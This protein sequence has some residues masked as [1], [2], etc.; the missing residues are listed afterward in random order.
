MGLVSLFLPEALLKL[1]G[2]LCT[3]TAHCFLDSSLEISIT[4][5]FN[6]VLVYLLVLLGI[7][8]FRWASK[9]TDTIVLKI[10]DTRAIS[11]STS[12]SSK[13]N[14]SGS[15]EDTTSLSLNVRS[16]SNLFRSLGFSSALQQSKRMLGTIWRLGFWLSKVLVFGLVAVIGVKSIAWI[17][18]VSF[19]RKFRFTS[20]R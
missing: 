14:S 8:T 10:N 5:I 7:K 12:L 4:V 15:N 6:L 2:R 3:P 17:T 11:T 20:R 9:I 16:V 18:T 1:F 19:T 13:S